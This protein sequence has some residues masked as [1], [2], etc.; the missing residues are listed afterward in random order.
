MWSL[1]MSSMDVMIPERWEVT[2]SLTRTR[3]KGEILSKN[4]ITCPMKA[5]PKLLR[6]IDKYDEIAVFVFLYFLIFFPV[7]CWRKVFKF[8]CWNA[9][10]LS[11]ISSLFAITFFSFLHQCFFKP[12]LFGLWKISAPLFIYFYLLWFMLWAGSCQ[13]SEPDLGRGIKRLSSRHL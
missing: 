10:G 3:G 4:R 6:G 2:S 11:V 8:L 9:F 12:H 13:L 1:D 7:I 5:L